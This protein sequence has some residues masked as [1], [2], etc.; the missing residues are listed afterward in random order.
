MAREGE[1]CTS[2]NG[3]MRTMI[4][5]LAF[6]LLAAPARAGGELEAKVNVEG[7]APK[8]AFTAPVSL[9]LIPGGGQVPAVNVGVDIKTYDGPRDLSGTPQAVIGDEAHFVSPAV[10]P[11]VGLARPEEKAA[12]ANGEIST[13]DKSGKQ[14]PRAEAA[15][16]GAS[17]R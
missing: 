12:A 15:P 5:L 2:Y 13:E 4:G 14:A 8:A 17:L 3:V 7:G 16:A 10:A 6:S 11:I 1:D 9:K